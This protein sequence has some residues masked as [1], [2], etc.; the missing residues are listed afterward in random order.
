M[1]FGPLRVAGW[2]FFDQSITHQSRREFLAFIK[3]HGF[4]SAP[5]D[6]PPG[7]ITT[8]GA[9]TRQIGFSHSRSFGSKSSITV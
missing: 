6:R 1:G 8:V 3:A 9:K 5:L 7:K 2:D 4:A